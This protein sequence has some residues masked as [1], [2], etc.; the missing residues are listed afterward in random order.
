MDKSFTLPY[1]FAVAKPA[2]FTPVKVKSP[3]PGYGLEPTV[4][5]MR[6]LS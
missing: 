3:P 5:R 1:I 2:R 6:G 4:P